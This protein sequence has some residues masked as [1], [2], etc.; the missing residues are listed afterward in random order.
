MACRGMLYAITPAEAQV[1]RGAVGDDD[2]LSGSVHCLYSGR[3]ESEGFQSPL[4]KA[5][6]AMHLCLTDGDGSF[7]NAVAPREMCIMGRPNLHEGDGYII[8]LVPAKIV[9]DVA[10]ALAEISEGW[11]SAQYDRL[12]PQEFDAAWH[13][14]DRDYTWSYFKSARELYRRAAAA[15]R[16]VLFVVDQ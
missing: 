4:D 9:P 16:A 11:M 12:V 1:I 7:G 14:T 6:Y 5:W 13:A 8:C 2:A 15:G 10:I 3:R